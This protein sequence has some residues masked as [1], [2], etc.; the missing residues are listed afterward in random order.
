MPTARDVIQQPRYKVSDANWCSSGERSEEPRLLTVSVSFLVGGVVALLASSLAGKVSNSAWGE[1]S[2]AGLVLSGLWSVPSTPGRNLSFGPSKAEEVLGELTPQ[3][4]RSAAAWFIAQT[5]ASGVRNSSKDCV[6]LTGP[7][8]VELYIP[9]KTEALSYME[10]RGPKPSR[11]ARITAVGP[12]GVQEYRLGPLEDGRVVKDAKLEKVAKVPL[13]KRPTEVGADP[14]LLMPLVNKT[15]LSLQTLLLEAFGPIFMQFDGFTGKQGSI[16]QFMRNHALV[17]KGSRVD[18]MKNLWVPPAPQ[19]PEAF[20]LHEVPIDITINTTSMNPKEWEVIEVTFCSQSYQTAEKLRDDHANGALK[21]CKLRQETGP[22]DYP[23]KEAKPSPAEKKVEEHGGVNWGPW[24]FTITQRPSTGP[25]LLDVRF[26]GERVLYEL[27]LQ[28]AQAAYAGNRHQQF[29]YSDASWSMSMLSASLEPGVDCPE[30]SHYLPATSWYQMQEGGSASTDPTEAFSLTP[31]CVFEWDE[32][33]TIWRHMDNSAPP[34]VHG[35]IRKTL[36][37]RFVCTVSNYDYITDVKFR[38]DGEIEVHTRFAG[39]LEARYYD[40]EFNAYEVNYSSIVRP[41]LA[42]PIHSHAVCFKA[43]IDVAGVR[44]NT[45]HTV[46]VGTETVNDLQS[47]VLVRHDVEHEGIGEST[48]VADATKPGHW[49]IVDRAAKSAAGNARGYS[50]SLSTWASTQVLSDSH[51]FTQAMP[52]TKYH[53]A[54]TKQHDEEYRVNSPYVQYDG[55]VTDG[56]A[57]NLDLFL[58]NREKILDED[59]V[60]WIG[61]GKEHIPRQEDLPLVSNFGVGFSLQ[62]MNFFEGNVVASPPKK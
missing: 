56:S 47:K 33:H 49:V 5:G 62:P 58:A 3:E 11:Q 7:S 24:S 34:S 45:L 43:D 18:I 9:S 40:P 23:Q 14:D 36:V 13:T 38:E 19:N 60:A 41:G 50:I 51:P 57:Q 17:P 6:W 53:L 27:S 26:K 20:W 55:Y 46:H 37:V 4:V 52:W 44:E 1:L 30:G 54:V 10:G 29:F 31:I 39:Y 8:A 21:I 2:S 59:L 16:V 35:N 22:W 42:G 15:F 32:D 48:F 28:D 61:I 25:A 12:Q